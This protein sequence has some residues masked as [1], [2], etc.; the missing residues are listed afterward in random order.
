MTR[1]TVI[2]SK[3]GSVFRTRDG[4]AKASSSGEQGDTEGLLRHLLTFSDLQV[5]YF[6]FYRGPRLSVNGNTLDVVEPYSSG[7]SEWSLGSEQEERFRKD[8]EVLESICESRPIGYINVC[9]YSPTFSVIDNPKGATVQQCNVLYTAPMLN[10][11]RHFKVP[12][13]LVNNDPR[14]YP[15]DQEMSLMWPEVIPAAL[16]DQCS[17]EKFQVVGGVEF[18]RRSAYA[19]C[20]SWLH[21]GVEVNESQPRT[22]C[23]IIAHAHIEDGCRQR[24]RNST[25]EN[26]LAPAE[27]LQV[28]YENGMRVYGAGWEHYVDYDPVL[29]PGK[30]KPNECIDVALGSKCCPITACAPYFYTGKPFLL[31]QCGCLPILYGDG[32]DPYTWDCNGQYMGLDHG[33]RIRKPGDLRRQIDSHV[34]NYDEFLPLYRET[35]KPNFTVLDACLAE[36]SDGADVTT[37][38]WFFKYGGYRLC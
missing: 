8:E 6:G 33:L 27:D 31:L 32:T 22:P 9:G 38:E 16:L 21:T 24:G 30:I 14:S 12:R 10:A 13:I 35:F 4:A 20:E 5:V 3:G 2:I 29:M 28:L 17:T 23:S 34:E 7:L 26:I 18:F 11:I 15:K 37:A 19:M 36:L 25:W 1:R